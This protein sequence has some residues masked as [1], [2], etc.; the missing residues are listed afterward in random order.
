MPIIKPVS[1]LQRNIKGITEICRETKEP[2]YLTKNGSAS[3]VVMDAEAY[4][5]QI[6]YLKREEEMRVYEGIMRGYEDV[7]AGRV[8]PADEVFDEI[9]RSRGWA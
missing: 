2:I 1:E 8:Y 6:A 3:L 4:D 9:A 7:K 5:E